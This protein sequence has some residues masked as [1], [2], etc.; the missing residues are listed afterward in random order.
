MPDFLAGS[1]LLQTI[2]LLD[3]AQNLDQI[4]DVYLKDGSIQ[5]LGSSLSSLDLPPQTQQ[6]RAESWILAPGLVDLYAHSGEPGHEQRQTLS[7]LAQSAW[8]GGYARVGLLPTTD[9]P[10]DSI[11]ALRAFQSKAQGIH[12]CPEW[13]PLAALTRHQITPLRPT[14]TESTLVEL[15]ELAQSEIAGFCHDRPLPSLQLTQRI[16]E[17]LQ[18]MDKPLLL[19]AWDP[20]QVGDGLIYE[21]EVS[22][23]LGLQGMPVT[24]ET[25]RVASLI[26][27]VRRTPTPVHLIRISCARSLDLIAQAQSDGLPITASVTW[28]H[29]LLCDQAIQ[30][31]TYHPALRLDPPLGSEAN[32]QAL[33]EGLKA[34]I[35]SAIATDHQ[36]FTFEEKSLPFGDAP[37]GAMGLELALPLLW[38]NL[39]TTLSPLT[40]WGSLTQGPLTCLRRSLDPILTGSHPCLVIFDPQS[41]WTVNTETI[42]SQSHSTPW[43]GRTLA[44]KVLAHLPATPLQL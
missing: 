19:W 40:L 29:L 12:P 5:A 16:L 35:L 7:S 4:T 41:R 26:E 18:P 13:L 3:P 24:A 21:G 38:Q 14:S 1:H 34:G 22:L 32:R 8:M 27:L 37:P 43:W 23:R 36:A 9:P 6:H 20:A 42:G 39:A 30:R 28:N 31:H 10:L 2:R 25:S 11:E 17:Y 15:G 44:G 33:I